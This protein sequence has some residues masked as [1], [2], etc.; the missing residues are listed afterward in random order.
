[1][2]IFVDEFNIAQYLDGYLE[3]KDIWDDLRRRYISYDTLCAM[4][5]GKIDINW[6]KKQKTIED[7]WSS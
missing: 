5:T 3:K 2:R 4:V 6:W 7:A 1:M